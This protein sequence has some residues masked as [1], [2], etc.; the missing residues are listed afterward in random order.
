MRWLREP[1]QGHAAR[2][3][4]RRASAFAR[5]EVSANRRATRDP[6]GNLWPLT[7]TLRN[8]V[9]GRDK[10]QVIGKSHRFILHCKKLCG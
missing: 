2:L 6:A 8:G 3:R 4:G 5:S 9:V 10:H 7:P 1:R